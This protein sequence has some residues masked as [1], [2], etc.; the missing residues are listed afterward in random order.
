MTSDGEDVYGGCPAREGTVTPGPGPGAESSVVFDPLIVDF[1]LKIDPGDW[2]TLQEKVIQVCAGKRRCEEMSPLDPEPCCQP[3]V[4]KI[5]V[6]AEF[7]FGDGPFTSAAIRVKGNP[8]DWQPDKLLQLIIRFDKYDKGS[9]FKGLRRLNLDASPADRSRMRNN[10]GMRVM[11]QSGVVASRSNHARLFINGEL[12]GVYENIEVVDE[13]FLEDRFASAEGNLYKHGQQQNLKTNEGDSG[14]H[15]QLDNIFD[16]FDHDDDWLFAELG[17]IAPVDQWLG[18]MA[19]EAVLP[20]SDNFWA[21]DFNFYFYVVPG[22]GSVV[23]PWDLDDVV[24]HNAAPGTDLFK[25]SGID[26]DPDDLTAGQ[27]GEY[28][29]EIQRNPVWRERF[30]ELVGVSLDTSYRHLPEWIDKTCCDLRPYM[31]ETEAT[32]HP[33]RAASS[34][35]GLRVFEAECGRL[36][37]RVRC[38]TSYLDAVLAGLP[39]PTC[40][41]S[42]K[43]FVV[44]ADAKLSC[45]DDPLGPMGDLVINEVSSVTDRI[46]II[47]RGNTAAWTVGWSL[48]AG[49]VDRQEI[50]PRVIQPG[51]IVV[52]LESEHDLSLKAQGEVLLWRPDGTEADRATWCKEAAEPSYCRQPDAVGGFVPCD[53]PTF[54]E[55]N[56][57]AEFTRRVVPAWQVTGIGALED[58]ALFDPLHATFD[59]DHKLWVIVKDY[60]HVM[61]FKGPAV[62]P[63]GDPPGESTEAATQQTPQNGVFVFQTSGIAEPTGIVGTTDGHVYVANRALRRLEV[64]E[65]DKPER[66][67][68]VELPAADDIHGLAV[69]AS[70][71]VYVAD[72]DLGAVL[73]VDGSGNVDKIYSPTPFG[74][75]ALPGP[76]AVGVYEEGAYKESGLLLVSTPGAPRLDTFVLQSGEW[77]PGHII[78][79]PQAGPSPRPGAFLGELSGIAVDATRGVLFTADQD[80]DRVM[81]HDLD[82]PGLYTGSYAV[83]GEFG[84]HSSGCA[85]LNDPRGLAVSVDDTWIAVAV[86]G[87]LDIEGAPPG[88][89]ALVHVYKLNQVYTLLGVE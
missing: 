84:V 44:P 19:A 32:K 11:R 10:V 47:N 66:V 38:R 89:E 81:L 43:A 59:M 48:S 4:R 46:E 86:D 68:K 23:I 3:G 76:E 34:Y 58:V 12:F 77:S 61:V 79:G 33:W 72:R 13:E 26:E 25:L 60:P 50:R 28:W 36:I 64:F 24:S 20:A 82:D 8:S 45:A 42:G 7:A 85:G 21:D 22:A 75:P 41:V 1:R 40:S 73:R 67:G 30:L 54:G 49:D 39:P 17:C 88:V 15:D 87:K 27:P 63:V 5:Y 62:A 14:G 53:T 35:E 29:E 55:P 65:T 31:A 83:L 2:Q 52:I 70:N 51:E 69:D 18:V 16:V 6:P 9:R 78:G 74:G 80:N 37:K 56:I 71:R 57:T